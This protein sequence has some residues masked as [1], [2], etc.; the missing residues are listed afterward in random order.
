[1]PSQY[2]SRVCGLVSDQSPNMMIAYQVSSIADNLKT[3]RP[4]IRRMPS[5][6]LWRIAVHCKMVELKIQDSLN[7]KH[8][9]TTKTNKIYKFCTTSK[10]RIYFMVIRSSVCCKG[11][12]KN[13]IQ[14]GIVYR[15]LEVQN[16]NS[17]FSDA[18][19]EHRSGFYE[20]P[21]VGLKIGRQ[22]PRIVFF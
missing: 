11:Q 19:L 12:K 15:N 7:F 2:S 17:R 3:N 21:Y 10:I 22:M 9:E 14:F 8:K 20:K 1:M 4:L 18:C 16:T 6:N 5:V 13:E